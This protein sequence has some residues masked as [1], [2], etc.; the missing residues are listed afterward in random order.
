M[1]QFSE[2]TFSKNQF[3]KKYSRSDRFNAT[4]FFLSVSLL[5][6]TAGCASTN[7]A[8]GD[9]VLIS[10]ESKAVSKAESKA[11]VV[12]QFEGVDLYGSY[13]RYDPH[14]S[15]E[16]RNAAPKGYLQ[17]PNDSL[18]G[19]GRWLRGYPMR[20]ESEPLTT[21]GGNFLAEP[22]VVGGIIDL[23]VVSPGTGSRE[24]LYSFMHEYAIVMQREMELNYRGL[25]DDSVSMYLYATGSYSTN[26][27]RTKYYWKETEEKALDANLL[28]RY[29]E[30]VRSVSSY[31]SLIRDCQEISI[32]DVLPGDLFIQYD[33]A[34]R[35]KG[36]LS[37]VLDV[38]VLDPEANI[39]EIGASLK[40]SS[41]DPYQRVFL[42]GNGLTPASSFHIIKPVKPGKGNWIVPGELAS[43]LKHI[44]PGKF[45]RIPYQYLR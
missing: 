40:D 11:V 32:A 24:V 31:K 26:F 22:T 37:I 17:I 18:R 41:G 28:N 27:N 1:K 4:L 35:P 34:P 44:G 15:I 25:A 20:S 8:I 36:H 19:F 13:S 16:K 7:S 39:A 14:S 2:K 6:L 12:D 30:F 9:S 29:T 5:S 23:P 45:Y 3:S 38:A 10:D 33:F 43:K 42:F 21:Y